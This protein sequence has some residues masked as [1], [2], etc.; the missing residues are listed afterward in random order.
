MSK[1]D[2]IKCP[3]TN[4]KPSLKVCKQL[5]LKPCELLKKT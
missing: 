4:N 5:C 3:K 1:L 2:K